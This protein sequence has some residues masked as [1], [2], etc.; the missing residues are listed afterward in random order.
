MPY[1]Q[2]PMRPTFGMIP[3]ANKIIFS[4]GLKIWN[5]T[6]VSLARNDYWVQPPMWRH[7]QLFLSR[8][9]AHCCENYIH[10]DI[11][12]LLREKTA[13]IFTFAKQ[14]FVA[15]P[16]LTRLLI[17]KNATTFYCDDLSI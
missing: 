5:R 16:P 8:P 11:Y 10:N 17:P 6:L 7:F 12:S 9:E 4:Y 2:T 14:G 15:G 13:Q 1:S 3:E